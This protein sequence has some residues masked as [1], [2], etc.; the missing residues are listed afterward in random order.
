M[1]KDDQGYDKFF[2]AK[3]LEFCITSTSVLKTVFSRGLRFGAVCPQ[4][5]QDKA[6]RI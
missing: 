5:V 4:C 2:L 6:L 3:Q 1:I